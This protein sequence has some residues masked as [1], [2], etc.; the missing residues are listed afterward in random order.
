MTFK[1]REHTYGRA[2]WNLWEIIPEPG[3]LNSLREGTKQRRR[4]IQTKAAA[5]L[6]AFSQNPAQ[7]RTILSDP[8]S[9][10]LPLVD[11]VAYKLLYDF[12]E[13]R[14]MVNRLL[15]MKLSEIFK[16]Y[17]IFLF[18][19]KQVKDLA[20]YYK[21]L[22]MNDPGSFYGSVN[23]I[24]KTSDFPSFIVPQRR[25]GRV[26]EFMVREKAMNTISKDLDPSL[27]AD[28]VKS[29]R[30]GTRYVFKGCWDTYSLV[31]DTIPQKKSRWNFI[32]KKRA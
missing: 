16:E 9:Q 27:K 31:F 22:N 14:V 13:E 23:A 24:K 17:C 7:V 32:C 8:V 6:T 12:V 29:I 10:R 1:K 3:T 19:E 20:P 26:L 21:R 15:K 18:D 30:K 28:V 25:F 11:A 4:N 5:D 2:L